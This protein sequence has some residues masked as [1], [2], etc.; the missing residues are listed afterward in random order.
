MEIQTD[1][2]HCLSLEVAEPLEA[3]SLILS[4]LV[5]LRWWEVVRRWRKLVV[6]GGWSVGKTVV[7]GGWWEAT[8]RG[9]SRWR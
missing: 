5:V 8:F 3:A 4:N 7:G 6:G 2:S 1:I 9:S